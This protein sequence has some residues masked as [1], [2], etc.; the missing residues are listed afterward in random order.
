MA[1]HN[2]IRLC[3]NSYDDNSDNGDTD[4]KDDNADNGDNDEKDDNADNGEYDDKAP[5]LAKDGRK[6]LYKAA[7]PS[8]RT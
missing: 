1:L 6:P 3:M 4:E 7:G 8:P 5:I 2:L